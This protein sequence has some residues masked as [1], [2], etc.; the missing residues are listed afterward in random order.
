MH[1]MQSIAEKHLFPSILSKSSD[2]KNQATEILAIALFPEELCTLS[3]L[4]TL[5]VLEG[6][7]HYLSELV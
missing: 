3:S 6:S 7:I 2:F 5:V 4:N 1:E